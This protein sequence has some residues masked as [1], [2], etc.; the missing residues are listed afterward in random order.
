LEFHAEPRGDRDEDGAMHSVDIGAGVDDDTALRL[1][2]GDRQK[3]LAQALMECMV[4]LFEAVSRTRPERGA[5]Q[6]FADGQIEDQCE[7]G[8]EIAQRKILQRSQV[9]EGQT[10]AIT[11]IGDRRIGETIADD[12][13]TRFEGGSDRPRHVIA[14][15]GKKQ[16]RLAYRVPTLGIALQQQGAY[17]LSARR[18]ARLAG[19]LCR[20]AD[21]IEGGNKKG[22]LGRFPGPLPALE[23]DEFSPFAQCRLPQIR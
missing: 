11:L 19:R 4:E 8:P 1:G 12:P 15:R 9:R 7:I 20:D 2:L 3:P 5:R 17:R 6:A 16:Q 14:A 22:S 10:A 18:P 13:S 23:R 21:A